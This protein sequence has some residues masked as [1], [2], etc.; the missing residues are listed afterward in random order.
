MGKR[1]DA[2]GSRDPVCP[3]LRALNSRFARAT[4]P[5]ELKPT[6]LSS[7]KIPWTSAAIKESPSTL[8]DHVA[9]FGG[10]R[11]GRVASGALGRLADRIDQLG[12]AHAALD[13][14]VEFEAQS[15]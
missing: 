14:G 5:A 2:S 13:R 6:G 9:V 8:V 10:V 12:Q 11:R 7:N 3:A 15:R 4:A 1:P